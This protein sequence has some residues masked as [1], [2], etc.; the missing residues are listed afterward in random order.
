MG[1]D[2]DGMDEAALR[3]TIGIFT[4]ALESF[5]EGSDDPQLAALSLKDFMAQVEATDNGGDLRVEKVM[6]TL[7][8][9]RFFFEHNG[10][11]ANHHLFELAQQPTSGLC[12]PCRIILR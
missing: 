6:G 9:L 2:F 5:G 11:R 3:Q 7:S 12:A 8:S 10:W 1:D 4:N